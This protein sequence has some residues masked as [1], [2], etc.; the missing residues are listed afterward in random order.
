MSMASQWMKVVVEK[1]S[2]FSI[3]RHSPTRGSRAGQDLWVP[4]AVL[5]SLAKFLACHPLLA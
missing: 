1:L 4:H 3:Y 5:A 2:D